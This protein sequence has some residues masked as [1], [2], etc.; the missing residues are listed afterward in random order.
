FRGRLV[1]RGGEAR[2]A[3][4]TPAAA[5]YEEPL[6][7]LGKI[8]QLLPGLGVVDHRSNRRLHVNRLPLV[9]GAIA[10]FA[11]ASTLGFVL[12][13]ETEMEESILVRTGDEVDITAAA[14]FAATRPAAWDILLPSKREAAITAVPGLDV[15]PD[16][17][18]E[19]VGQC[20]FA[21]KN[22]FGSLNRLRFKNCRG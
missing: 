17:V 19:H 12:G 8:V 1:C 22:L 20:S 4:S 10:A 18:D 15:N 5:G 14:A 21:A 2:V 9:S 16:F 6:A 7:G 11:M 13:V 3:A